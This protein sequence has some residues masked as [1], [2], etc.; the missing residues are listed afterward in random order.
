MQRMPSSQPWGQ[1]MVDNAIFY[2]HLAMIEGADQPW[3][4]ILVSGWKGLRPKCMNLPAANDHDRI[5]FRRK[6]FDFPLQ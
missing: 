5:R 3:A 4:F 6:G 1:A 2:P